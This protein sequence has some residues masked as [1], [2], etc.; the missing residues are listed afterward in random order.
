[1][2]LGKNTVSLPALLARKSSLPPYRGTSHRV[3]APAIILARLRLSLRTISIDP[4]VR[5][6][7]WPKPNSRVTSRHLNLSIVCQQSAHDAAI[8]ERPLLGSAIAALKLDRGNIRK[9]C[10]LLDL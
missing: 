5:Q 7:A 2:A 1:M 4:R 3:R 6:A 8:D 9:S 10:S